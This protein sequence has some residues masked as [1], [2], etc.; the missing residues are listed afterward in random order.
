MHNDSTTPR[1]LIPVPDWPQYHPWPNVQNL[2]WLIFNSAHNGFGRC[3]RRDGRRILIDEQ[4]FF[5]WVDA[6]GDPPLRIVE[7]E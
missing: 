2:W 1:R 4:A 6:Q 3:I 7:E 5:R